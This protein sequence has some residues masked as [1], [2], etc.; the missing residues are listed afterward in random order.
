MTILFAPCT[1]PLFVLPALDVEDH[2]ETDKGVECVL[3]EAIC[4]FRRPIALPE[5]KSSHLPS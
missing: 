2:M 4:A 1:E 5:S 3:A